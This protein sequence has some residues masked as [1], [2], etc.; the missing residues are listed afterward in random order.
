MAGYLRKKTHVVPTVQARASADAASGES[1]NEASVIITREGVKVPAGDVRLTVSEVTKLTGVPTTKLRHYDS[2][3]LLCPARSGEGVSN[4]RKLYDSGD[5]E[6]LQTILTLSAYDFSL[7]EIRHVLDDADTDLYE[8]MN[9]KLLAL[10]LHENRL[11]NLIHFAQFIDLTDTELLEGLACGPADLDLLADF[12]RRS[13]QYHQ[14]LQ[15]LLG[16][17][18]EEAEVV[19]EPLE[20][21]VVEYLLLDE[22][23]GFADTERVMDVFLTWWSDA[24][25]PVEQVG[26]LG[27]WAIFE[28][29]SLVA[30]RVEAVGGEGVAGFL[31]MS[32][33]FVMMKRLLEEQSARIHAVAELAEADVVAAL[34]SAQTL[35][36][37][38]GHVVLGSKVAETCTLEERAAVA[39]CTLGYA[40]GILASEAL[41]AHLELGENLNVSSRDIELAAKVVEVMCEGE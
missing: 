7:E 11:R 38:I 3:G 6:R 16:M 37:A 32:V 34:E 5:L 39:L 26:Y 9:E 40:E 28:D 24:I 22:T 18:D 2:V 21:T 27:F 12:A 14:I 13:P 35:V 20:P 19:L 30:E 17:S 29:H 25:A 4:N 10:K 8:V 15:R 33:F 41:R 36:A 31:E 1:A 23:E